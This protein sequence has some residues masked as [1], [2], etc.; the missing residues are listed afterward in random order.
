MAGK[1]ACAGLVRAEG[2]KVIADVTTS[3]IKVEGWFIMRS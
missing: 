1:G 2:V 3:K